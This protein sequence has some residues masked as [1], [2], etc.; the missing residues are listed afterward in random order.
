MIRMLPAEPTYYEGTYKIEDGFNAT[1]PIITKFDDYESYSFDERNNT[2]AILHDTKKRIVIRYDAQFFHSF[3]HTLAPILY[4]YKK[5]KEIEVILL[6]P[7]KEKDIFKSS[8]IFI[9]EVLRRY[10]IAYQVVQTHSKYPPIISNFYYYEKVELCGEFIKCLDEFVDYYRDH[11]LTNNKMVYVSRE[12][13]QNLLATQLD[14]M[15]Q[16]DINK[17]D[18]TDDFRIDDEVKLEGLMESLGFEIVYTGRFKSIEEQIKFFDQVGIVVALS[19][20]GLT[21]LLFMREGTKVVELSTTQLLRRNIE[22]HFHFYLISTIF[23][24]KTYISVPNVD[25]K[26]DKIEGRVKEIIERIK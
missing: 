18:F 12:G 8:G 25:R 19:G 24:K 13:K 1:K 3:F 5:D 22:F 14:F 7:S 15:S 17:L 26:Y 2:D 10:G 11:S 21:N 20:S 16:E 23:S 9:I 4:E 6:Q